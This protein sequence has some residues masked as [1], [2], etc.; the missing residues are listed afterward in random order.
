MEP[1]ASIIPSITPGEEL[2]SKGYT[3]QNDNK[4]LEEVQNP[5]LL[6]LGRVALKRYHFFSSSNLFIACLFLLQ[7]SGM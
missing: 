2:S 6:F 3:D 4:E 7:P 5:N 1:F